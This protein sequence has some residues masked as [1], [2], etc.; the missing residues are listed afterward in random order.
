M[1]LNESAIVDNLKAHRNAVAALPAICRDVPIDRAE[2]VRRQKEAAAHSSV[3]TNTAAA[4]RMSLIPTAGGYSY[5]V[6]GDLS[7]PS[8]TVEQRDLLRTVLAAIIRDEQ[9]GGPL[10]V[11]LE[12]ERDKRLLLLDQTLVAMG[13]Q[14]DRFANFTSQQQKLLRALEGKGKVTIAAAY[15]AVHGRR[16]MN[17]SSFLKF[18]IRTNEQLDI[19]K[20]NLEI[21]REGNTLELQPRPIPLPKSH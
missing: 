5:D 19:K 18:I 7:N 13:Q 9:L 4:L 6:N 21:M 1:P 12:P 8:L 17:R 2:N 3:I 15:R 11:E 16:T 20:S 14:P 10:L